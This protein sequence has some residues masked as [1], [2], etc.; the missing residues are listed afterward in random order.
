MKTFIQ[1]HRKLLIILPVILLIV[2]GITALVK[3][4]L[5]G[6]PKIAG[7]DSTEI[8]NF[9]QEFPAPK[10]RDKEKNKFEIYMQ[11]QKDTGKLPSQENAMNRRVFDPGPPEDI[12]DQKTPGSTSTKRTPNQSIEWQEKQMN[13]QMERI[14][15]E[16]NKKPEEQP[17]TNFDHAATQSS[18]RQQEIQQLEEMIAGIRQSGNAG[19]SEMARLNTMLDKLV[20]LEDPAPSDTATAVKDTAFYHQVTLNPQATP[21][22]TGFYSLPA[23]AVS[24]QKKKKAIRA[25]ALGGQVLVNGSTVKLRLQEKIFLDQVEIPSFTQVDGLCR[26]NDERLLITVTRII[27][28]GVMYPVQL[29]VYDT[30]GMQGLHAPGAITRDA[31]KDQ[32]AQTMQSSGRYNVS[33]GVAG[34]LASSAVQGVGNILSRKTRLVKIQIPTD[35]HV[36]LQ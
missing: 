17:S 16:M 9:N 7:V 27:H 14:L 29:S 34:D 10:I 8:N 22:P 15:Q 24:P 5:S 33:T 32:L 26:I 2:V 12:P 36:F 31:A 25:L 35:F 23:E 11:A 28:E 4:H 19:E 30:H 6:S 20:S 13:K 18:A 21:A 1:K 3:Q